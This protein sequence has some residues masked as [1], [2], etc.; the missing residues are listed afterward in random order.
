MSGPKT[1]NISVRTNA[2]RSTPDAFLMPKIEKTIPTIPPVR[3]R[4]R[5]LGMH[6]KRNFGALF[7]K[8]HIEPHATPKSAKAAYSYAIQRYVSPMRGIYPVSFIS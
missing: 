5:K 8:K 4:I 1:E 7:V 3:A 2:F 6:A